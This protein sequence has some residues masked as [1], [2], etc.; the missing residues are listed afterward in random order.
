M[1]ACT[2]TRGSKCHLPGQPGNT[3][4]GWPFGGLKSRLIQGVSAF[5]QSRSVGAGASRTRMAWP[6]GGDVAHARA[7]LQARAKPKLPQIAGD[8]DG[9]KMFEGSRNRIPFRNQGVDKSVDKSMALDMA[10][11]ESRLPLCLYIYICFFPA[12]SEQPQRI[13]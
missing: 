10:P 4:G 6:R 9:L 1:Q 7:F 11:L 2:W 8:W 12:R 3:F 13:P 5:S